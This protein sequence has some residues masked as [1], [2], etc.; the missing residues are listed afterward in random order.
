MIANAH[1]TLLIGVS[2]QTGAFDERVIRTM[3]AHVERP[4]V[5]P[6]SNPTSKAEGAPADILAWS[7]GRA[8]VGTGSPFPPVGGRHI[9]QTNNS[10]IFPGVGLGVLAA[11]ARRVTDAMF[12]ASA[13]ALAEL[14]PAIADPLAPLLPPVTALR[15][16]SL[17]VACA[18]ARQA[19]ADGVAD[20]VDD[21]VLEVRLQAQIWNPVYRRYLRRQR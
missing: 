18:V 3:A 12:M 9:A 20:L 11:R 10:Y 14:S 4:V 1:P 17:A 2:G 19:M 7:D 5:F 16:V 21:A 6:L 15:A 13:H 8:L